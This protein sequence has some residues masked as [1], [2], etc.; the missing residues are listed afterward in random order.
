MSGYDLIIVGAGPGGYEAAAH[1]GKHG[2]RVLLIEKELLG[3]T[4]L[5]RGCIPTKNLL[6]AAHFWHKLNRSSIFNISVENPKF[7]FSKIIEKKD[8]LLLRLRKGVE[9]LLKQS[10]VELLSGEAEL[11]P[12]KIVRVNGQEYTAANII[13]AA[14]SSPAQLPGLSGQENVLDSTQILAMEKIPKTM[15][16]IGAGAIGLEFADIFNSFGTEITVLEI[17]PQVLPMEEREAVETLQKT[18][19]QNGIK[20][21]CRVKIKKI[22]AGQVELDNGEKIDAEIVLTAAG[23]K[24]NSGLPGIYAIGDINNRALYA[25]AATY[26]GLKVVDNIINKT[27]SPI[28]LTLVP[29]VVFTSP[30]IAALG[31]VDGVGQRIKKMPLMMLGRAQ[32]ENQTV[33]FIKIFTESD[34]GVIEGVVIVAENAESLI[35]SA[36]VLV[37]KCVTVAELA[38]MIHPHPTFAELFSEAVKL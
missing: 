7:D 25:H 19:E 6:A 34:T 5:N 8:R 29:R 3:G 21:K 26:Q 37:N 17:L 24:L 2:L 11:L 35:A 22:Q 33:G 15:A 13:L 28:D 38:E 20:F 16:I 30:Q 9:N 4:C 27:N 10:K 32:A 36:V 31:K 14:G 18:M 1:A 12:N 23:R